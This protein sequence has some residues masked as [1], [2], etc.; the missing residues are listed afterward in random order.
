V[1]VI[2]TQLSCLD[3]FCSDT[4]FIAKKP[5]LIDTPN[6]LFEISRLK[7]FPQEPLETCFSSVILPLVGEAAQVINFMEGPP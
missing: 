2:E 3:L 4:K 6:V 7:T 5:N 1:T